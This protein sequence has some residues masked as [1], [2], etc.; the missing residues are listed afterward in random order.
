MAAKRKLPDPGHRPHGFQTEAE[1]AA[2][3]RHP[4]AI[5]QTPQKLSHRS[6]H[7]LTLPDYLWRWLKDEAHR[8]D[9]PQ[10]LII[11]RALKA[12]GAPIEQRDL[13][14]GRKVR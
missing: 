6:G 11:M 4:P 7:S 10:N 14:D 13:V 2:T 9:E 1:V 12:Q 5:R 8:R 3:V